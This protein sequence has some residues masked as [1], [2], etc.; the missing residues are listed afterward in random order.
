MNAK[1]V[2]FILLSSF[3]FQ[4]LPAQVSRL[5]E[6]YHEEASDPYLPNSH[7]NKKVSPAYNYR[8]TPNIYNT[9]SSI[10]FTQQVN[11]NANGQNIL[12]DAANEPSIAIN[13]LNKSEIVIGWRQ[14]DNISSNFRQAGWSYSSDSGQ[15]WTFPGVIEPGV[16]RSDPVLDFDN[17]GNIYYNSLTNSPTFMTS[18]F[19]STNG[20]TS[21][22][23]GVSAQGGDKQW[24]TVDRSSGTGTDNI[25]SF[26]SSSYSVCN[27]DHFTRSTNS[28][29]SFENC[30]SVDGDPFWGTM[31]VNNNGDLLISGLSNLLGE[32]ICVQS[33]NA[34]TAGSTIVWNSPSIVDLDGYLVAGA[35]VNPGGLLGQ[36]N[37]DVDRSGGAG[38]G[39]IYILSP[40]Q[41]TSNGDPADIMFARSTDGGINFDAPVQINDDSSFASQ[42]MGTMSVAPNGRIDIV[43]L[44]TKEDVTFTDSSALYYSYSIDQGVSWSTDE[45]ISQLFNPH[46]GYPN[47]NKM[48]DYFHMISDNTSAHLAWA[49]TLNGEQDVYYSRITPQITSVNKNPVLTLNIFPNPADKLLYISGDNFEKVW[50]TNSLGVKMSII[51]INQNTIDISNL[52][53]GMYFVTISNTQSE[54]VTK[55]FIKK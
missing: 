45:K 35:N 55:K 6:S 37:I 47:Q 10:V 13:P 50:L 14:F 44:D 43:W 16:F 52:T 51:Y 54:K 18:V 12:D 41:R 28:A 9:S 30:T 4:S 31:T 8:I 11:V 42:W 5:S 22:N 34:Q 48:G 38:N 26:W 40:V 29:A 15:T 24:M 3:I 1:K 21:W 36:I 46:V 20:G 17:D 49:N 25:Y 32:I 53:A 19:K 27:P 23:S 2:I 33:S 39:N 7:Q